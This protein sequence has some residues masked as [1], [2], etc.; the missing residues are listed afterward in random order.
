MDGPWSYDTTT[1]FREAYTLSF[2]IVVLPFLGF[3][4]L[5]GLIANGFA[6]L[7]LIDLVATGAWIVYLR[8]R[9]ELTWRRW[10]LERGGVFR[11]GVQLFGGHL[12]A[13]IIRTSPSSKS[14][15]AWRGA[16]GSAG[17]TPARA[18]A[19]TCFG[20]RPRRPASA[21]S[22]RCAS[23]TPL[24]R[25]TSWRNRSTRRYSAWAVSWLERL[26]CRCTGS[27]P[28]LPLLRRCH[29]PRR[30]CAREGSRA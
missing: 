20:F 10:R 3:L 8:R 15:I 25:V 16:A 11:E 30:P 21:S 29:R 9:P 19:R 26:A 7:A 6:Q 1:N 18:T 24:A 17:A 2:L 4:A 28:A 27:L 14:L 22:L 12:G 5:L 23:S 13:R